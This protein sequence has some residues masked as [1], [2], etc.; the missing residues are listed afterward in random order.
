LHVNTKKHGQILES[1]RK[2][3][4]FK[5]NITMKKNITV[6]I[7]KI[8][9]FSYPNIKFQA[10]WF[11]SLVTVHVTPREITRGGLPP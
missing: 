6:S 11:L 4:K 8:E 5:Y 3:L 2:D 9:L 7:E 1:K 10:I